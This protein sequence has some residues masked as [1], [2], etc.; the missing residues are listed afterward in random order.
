M[1]SKSY[2]FSFSFLLILCLSLFFSEMALALKG[3]DNS[4][5]PSGLQK[6]AAG[7]YWQY[8][9]GD[10]IYT[11][12]S[13]D[14]IYWSA[15]NPVFPRG[16]W[17]SWIND[18]VP[19][20]RGHFWAPD[21]IYMN[22]QYY[23]YYS[24]SSFGSSRSVIGLATSPTLDQNSP[25]YKWTDQGM[26]VYSDSDN[27]IN[28]IDPALFMDSDG[29]VYMTYGSW[30]GGIGVIELN[31]STGK[32]KSG[33]NLY[34]VAG[35][36]HADWEAPYLIKEGSYYYIFI[37]RGTCCNGVNSTYHIKMGRSTSPTGPFV[38]KD[39]VDLNNNGG[40]TVLDKSG[41]YI[42]PG[43]FGLLRENGTKYVSLHY[44]DGQDNGNAKLDI[45]TMRMVH[46]WP[47]LTR[48]WI[49]DGQY[50][51]TNKNSNL[52]WEA[53]EAWGCAGANG[54]A[55]AQAAPAE[56]D[57]QKWNFK[58]LGDGAFTRSLLK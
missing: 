51:V 12:S 3:N 16:T 49:A 9:T 21:L 25:D 53:W 29:R 19:S 5:D 45:L 37:N 13:P 2:H 40:T 26:V 50:A 43:H 57:C 24:C 14:L 46:D 31:S 18:Y 33:A 55:I 1:Q 22:G 4:H 47:Y 41:R 34:K 48:D 10:G 15:K 54:E 28:A 44:Y 52:A 8:T 30:F 58:P 38:D 27:D 39:G 32:V 23:L 11:A 17:P 42:G 35:G 36:G 20:F 7:N 56:K 6:D